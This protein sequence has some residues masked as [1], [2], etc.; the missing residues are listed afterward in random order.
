MPKITVIGRCRLCLLDDIPLQESHIV[1]RFL[2]RDSGVTGSGRSFSLWSES[3]PDLSRRHV[4]D[5]FKEHLLCLKCEG[6]FGKLETYAKPMLFGPTSPIIQRPPS[7]HV[8][9]GLDYKKMKLFHMSIL[10]RMAASANPFYTFVKIADDERETLRQMLLADDPGSPWQYGCL[11][12]LLRHRGKPLLGILSQP[13]A[14]RIRRDHCFR[15][16]LAGMQWFM[17]DSCNMPKDAPVETFL[18]H[19]GTWALMQGEAEDYKYLRD[20]IN[21]LKKRLCSNQEG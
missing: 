1:P 4:Q 8:W 20:E 21:D 15:L 16:V 13:R 17:F 12:T 7:H 2:W 11:V 14:I 5:G 10:W 9:T 6:R 18:S 3:H 19:E